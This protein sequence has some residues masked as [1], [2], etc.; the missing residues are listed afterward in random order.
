MIHTIPITLYAALLHCR[1]RHNQNCTQT[2]IL[3]VITLPNNQILHKCWI[4]PKWEN[5][6]STNCR[7]IVSC[8]I[9]RYTR[10]CN[11][12]NYFGWHK[13]FLLHQI[14]V[15][16]ASNLQKTAYHLSWARQYP[17]NFNKNVKNISGYAKWAK[18][19]YR[20]ISAALE[21]LFGCNSTITL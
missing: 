18:C 15:V 1:L 11:L 10:K 19:Y 2:F 6:I 8:V 12:V 3:C 21:S 14:D 4:L 13:I 5:M 20:S 17:G 9:I 7:S 16:N